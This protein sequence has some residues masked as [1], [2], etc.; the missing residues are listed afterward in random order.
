MKKLFWMGLIGIVLFET[1]NVFFIMPMPGSQ[2]MNSI[3]LAYFL[4]NWRWIFRIIFLLLIIGGLFLSTWVNKWMWTIP[5][6]FAA[7]IIYMANFRMAADHMFRKTK[8]LLLAGAA[9]NA[10]DKN[11]LI[12]GVNIGGQAKAYPIQFLGYH[13]QVIDTIGG[14]LLMI[15]YCTV[16]RSGRVFEPIVNGKPEEFRLVG[17]DHF[18]AMFEDKTT[19]SWWR[20]ETGEAIAGKLKGYHLPE[21]FSVQTSLAKWLQL[22]PNSLIMQ[23]D[24]N[25]TKNYDSTFRFETGKSKSPLTGTD[26]LSWKDKSW[27]VALTVGKNSKAYDWNRLKKERFINDKIDDTP[28]LVVL[29]NDNNSFFAFV[30]PSDSAFS[31]IGDTLLSGEGK[32]MIDGTAIN[33][34]ASLR[35]LP[36]YQEFWHSWKTFHPGTQRY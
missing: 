32:Y 23:P 12:I 14:K 10:V 16:C 19:R 35:P 4:Y 8:S 3:S 5:I 29:A 11:R 15:T 33:S 27:V 17:M 25:F 20:Q 9:T 31:I 13:H 7:G 28:V 22:Y 21:V 2:R 6:V 30:R 26:S 34:K 18:N 36:A 24:P 1:A